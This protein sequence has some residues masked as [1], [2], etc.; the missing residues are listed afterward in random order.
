M[1]DKEKKKW[2]YVINGSIAM[3]RAILE[4]D[5]KLFAIY[6][7]T[8]YF[9]YKI[10]TFH[11][12]LYD[13]C[14]RLTNGTYD[15]IM[16]CIFREGAKTSIAK[17]ALLSWV[18]CFKK[19]TNI[20][21][22]SY[23]QESGESALFDVTVAL[24]TNKRLIS[25]FGQLYYKKQTKEA[26][27]EAK[28]KRLKNFKTENGIS[29]A[30]VT[31]QQALR[32]RNLQGSERTDLY[33]VDDIENNKTKDSSV[34]TAG[35]IKHIEEL[36][37]GL[38]AGGSVLYL[39]NFITDSGSV[40]YIMDV[41]KNNP[42]AIVRSIPVVDSKG[43]IAWPSKFVHTDAEAIEVN[44]TIEDPKKH[45]ISLEAKRRDLKPAVYDAEYMLNPA[46]SGDL[47]FEREKVM[48]AIEHA[49]LPSET[50]ADFKMWGKFNPKHRYGGGADTAE[51]IGGDSNASCWFDFT[52][53]PNLLIGSFE[54]NNMPA[55]T[56]GWELKRQGAIL[57]YP[58][59]VP[60]INQTGYATIAE[61]IN[62]NY[63]KLYQREVKNKTNGVMQKELGWKA[64]VGTKH[65]VMADFK[66]SFEDGEFEIFDAGLLEEMKFYKKSDARIAN[67]EKGATRHFDKLR[68]A[69]L[70]WHAR[71]WAPLAQDERKQKYHVPGLDKPY[72]L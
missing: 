1:N 15:E 13:D 48:Q 38:S 31:T 66:T 35:V 56:F 22:D 2:D 11:N 29:I 20:K 68:A 37:S 4:R 57:S 58:F 12:D 45:K 18:I 34:I 27:S 8:D 41:L 24:Q 3:R 70:A 40:A 46:K 53:V 49:R 47:F 62:A 59:L 17:T 55:N 6:Y 63:P 60:E 33:I 51:G 10:P 42:R 67:R 25:D 28:M 14:V 19:K 9:K 23:E 44:R 5:P 61:L 69:A 64:T 72:I 16:W 36:R 52:V 26:L 39:C 7:F 50:I 32:A 43:V 21:W 54:D 71:K 65:E 30:T